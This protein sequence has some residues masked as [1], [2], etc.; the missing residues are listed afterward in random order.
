MTVTLLSTIAPVRQDG[1]MMFPASC[2][3]TRNSRAK[4]FSVASNEHRDPFQRK[5]LTVKSPIETLCRGF[6][7][8]TTRYPTQERR[9]RLP[10]SRK[11]WRQ[12]YPTQG[13]LLHSTERPNSIKVGPCRM[14]CAW[15]SHLSK[16]SRWNSTILQLVGPGQ[17]YIT[18]CE[19]TKG[20]RILPCSYRRSR[21][22]FNYRLPNG[23][24]SCCWMQ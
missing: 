18:D 14:V 13:L 11:C 1:I 10:A 15:V 9:R 24:S 12:S 8:V 7:C 19:W 23:V 3:Y 17:F 6:L 20:V 22:S 21:L 5:A 4:R 2:T 16:K